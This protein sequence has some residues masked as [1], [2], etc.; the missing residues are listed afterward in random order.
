MLRALMT[1]VPT[2]RQGSRNRACTLRLESLEERDVPASLVWTAADSNLWSD[3]DNWEV[4]ANGQLTGVHRTPVSTD[5]LYFGSLGGA[6]VSSVADLDTTV[7]SIIQNNTYTGALDIDAAITVTISGSF[8]AYGAIDL[9]A[10]GAELV[11]GDI[12]LIGGSI[13]VEAQAVPNTDVP[14][15]ADMLDMVTGATL[16]V[17]G[18]T[19]AT[20][21]AIGHLV[22]GAGTTFAVT[23]TTIAVTLDG[24]IGTSGTVSVAEESDLTVTGDYAQAAGELHLNDNCTLTI[25]GT[26]PTNLS[27]HTFI[28]GDVEIIADTVQIDGSGVLEYTSLGFGDELA[29]SGDLEVR[30]GTF[31]F[32]EISGVVRVA[33]DFSV[34]IGT[35]NM[36]VAVDG[37]GT[38][39]S[40]QFIVTGS[41]TLGAGGGG[42]PTLN[43]IQLTSITP[44]V[45]F[46]LINS[47]TGSGD[48]DT[49]S[50]SNTVLAQG[51]VGAVYSVTL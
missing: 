16:T 38:A 37:M 26:S 7:A 42:G 5:T 2:T 31:E 29:F 40:N 14:L 27:G 51:F 20:T 10:N 23:G 18:A 50:A 48:F 36:N 9:T 45:V 47:G 1:R 13:Q 49:V 17:S 46:A 12:Y 24:E 6:N 28:E 34:F 43:L 33:G 35:I 19:G 39:I 25:G 22:M 21:L 8:T 44:A 41:T 11:A 30:S 15:T 32:T 4:F 3:P